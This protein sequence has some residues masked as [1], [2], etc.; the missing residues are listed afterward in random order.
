MT[1]S[2]LRQRFLLALATG[3]LLCAGSLQAAPV[4]GRDFTKLAT[5]QTPQTQDRIEVIEFFSWG[6]PHCDRFHPLITP[7]AAKL[8]ANVKFI[9]VPVSMGH[10]QW[11]QL[12]R[13]YYALEATGDLERLDSAVF[14]AL[15]RQGLRL[16]DE[17]SITAWVASQ[18]VNAGKFYTAFNSPE[19]SMRA[20]QAEQLS[21]DYQVQGIPK[22]T[23]A[24]KYEVHANDFN[25]MLVNATQVIQLVMTEEN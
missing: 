11:G 5:P 3:A 15:H 7:W 25:Q 23:V 9:R 24:G 12:V 2:S 6:C 20:Q 13:T 8:P 14:D 10:Q 18:G 4:E 1:G 22:I 17:P 16:F 21:R 19:V